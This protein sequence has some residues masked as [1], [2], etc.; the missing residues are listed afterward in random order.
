MLKFNLARD[1]MH[2]L[3]GLRACEELQ[4]DG[5]ADTVVPDALLDEEY[6]EHAGTLWHL[7]DGPDSDQGGWAHGT[8]PDGKHEF[9][10]LADPQPLGGKASAPKPDPALYATY[11]PEGLIAKVK[12]AV[13]GS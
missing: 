12:N 4:A 3:Q 9:S 7:S 10:F 6:R 13:T 11:S 2:Q 1:T 5:L 8:A